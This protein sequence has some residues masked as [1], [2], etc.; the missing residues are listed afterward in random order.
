MP[1]ART[2]NKLFSPYTVMGITLRN[3]IIRSATMEGMAAAD[4]AP[5]P[6]LT[7]L[8]ADLA[9]GGV[10]LISTGACLAD[11]TWIPDAEGHLFLDTDDALRTWEAAVRQV[12]DL[13]G[14]ISLQLAPFF[15]Y[16]Q[17]PVGPSAYREG[18]CALTVD[19]IGQLVETTAQCARRAWKAGFDAVQVHAGHGYPISQ[20]ISPFY[21][22]REDAYGGAVENRLC[23]LVEM[24]QAISRMTSS[25]FPVWIKLNSFDGRPGGMVPEDIAAYGP[26]LKNA[27]YGIIEVTGGSPGGSHSSRGPVNE[28]DWVEGFYLEGAAMIKSK[29]DL[30]VSA[31]GGIRRLEMIRDIFS[32]QMA[33]LIS[34]SRP[35]IREPYLANRWAAGDLRPALCTSCNGC[36]T[37]MNK[38]RGLYCVMERKRKKRVRTGTGSQDPK[39]DGSR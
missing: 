12:H 18:I 28:A 13:G 4:G 24:K 39:A 21:N 1:L 22:R 8:Y 7:R 26:I 20:F 38:K 31:V 34:L 6:A 27:G 15:Y 3:R 14:A 16:H 10:G 9:S 33:D 35:L 36:S 29:T 5:S 32:N 25:D 11:R 30:P 37:M 23:I 2:L 17:R 19:E